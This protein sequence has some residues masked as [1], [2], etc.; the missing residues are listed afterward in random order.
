MHL[1]RKDREGAQRGFFKRFGDSDFGG[2]HCKSFKDLYRPE[3]VEMLDN[4]YQV[5]LSSRQFAKPDATQG[6]ENAQCLIGKYY[7]LAKSTKILA[8]KFQKLGKLNTKGI[9]YKNNKMFEKVITI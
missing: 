4:G 8:F 7:A 6:E 1:N 5:F 2:L 9:N 3:T